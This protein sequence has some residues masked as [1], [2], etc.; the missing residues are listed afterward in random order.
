[1]HAV[2][3]LVVAQHADPPLAADLRVRVLQLHDALG[4]QVEHHHARPH[5]AE[6]DLFGARIHDSKDGRLL[7]HAI[8]ERGVDPAVIGRR[9]VLVED[10]QA[11][12]HP[13]GQIAHK[14]L[15][16][17]Q[18]LFERSRLRLARTCGH[19]RL[20]RRARSDEAHSPARIDDGEP[21]DVPHPTCAASILPI[22]R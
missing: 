18:E 13:L 9:V 21:H 2:R 3:R 5:G 15:G 20:E 22:Q 6:A 16:R 14:W 10:G 12:Q 8:V 7:R 19:Q 11:A 17:L 4:Q 1:M